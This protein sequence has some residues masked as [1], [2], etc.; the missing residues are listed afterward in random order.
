M[1]MGKGTTLV[2]SKTALSV[3][4]TLPLASDLLHQVAQPCG[5]TPAS[6]PNA[7]AAGRLQRL[8]RPAALCH[9]MATQDSP[10]RQKTP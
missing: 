9:V 7:A 1:G 8:K 4:L 2:G 5:P 6:S 10:L 3:P